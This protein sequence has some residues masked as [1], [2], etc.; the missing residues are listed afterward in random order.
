M[1]EGRKGLIDKF[2][3]LCDAVSAELSD[4]AAAVYVAA[5]EAMEISDKLDSVVSVMEKMLSEIEGLRADFKAY[6]EL[7][8]TE[9]PKPEQAPVPPE[10]FIP[11]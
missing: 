8:K 11:K 3:E 5:T 2:E 6:T 1:G 9:K 10:V 7:L 4:A